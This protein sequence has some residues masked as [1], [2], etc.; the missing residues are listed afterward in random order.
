MAKR[1][2]S[3]PSL[4]RDR[5]RYQQ[6]GP[7]GSIVWALPSTRRA[8]LRDAVRVT[9]TAAIAREIDRTVMLQMIDTA[10][11]EIEAAAQADEQR[12]A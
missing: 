10:F 2:G 3:T 7:L 9:A 5:C 11:D 8:V 6:L 12:C 4:T 1:N